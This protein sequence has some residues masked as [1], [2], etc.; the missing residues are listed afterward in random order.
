LIYIKFAMLEQIISFFKNFD[1]TKTETLEE[2]Y[3][4]RPFIPTVDLSEDSGHFN[5]LTI[6]KQ[7]QIADNAV[8]SFGRKDYFKICL[9]SGNSKIHYADKSFEIVKHG[10][11]FA[12]PLIPYDWEAISGEQVGYSCIFTESFIDGFGNIKKYPFF[13]PGGYPVFE[14][15]VEEKTMIEHI[16]I[17]MQHEHQSMFDFKDDAIK[18]LIFQI[19]FS[20]L[21]IRPT[22]KLI[23]EKASA[24]ARIT[25]LFLN[26]LEKQFPI[27][28]TFEGISLRSA[29]DFAKQM[30]IHVNHLNKSLKEI[31]FKTTS[32]IISER[33]L[34]EA[35]ILLKHSSWAISEIAYSLG[36]EGP[37]HF[38]SFFKKQMRQSPSQYRSKG[39][40]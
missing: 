14:L 23:T 40:L 37:A 17:Q 4:K 10:L 29:S 24:S 34:K 22:T 11:L 39:G 1:M 5:I 2:Y 27:K 36:F 9:V 38:S 31:T 6:E 18:N 35:K 28:N 13:Q 7:T 33:I 16:F 25:F 3:A 12:H 15:T 32:E 30:A 26:L 20:A 21:K 19:I 8:T